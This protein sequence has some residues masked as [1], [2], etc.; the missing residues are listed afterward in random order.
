MLMARLCALILV[1]LLA[2]S[3]AFAQGQKRP[4]APAPPTAPHPAP[5]P[6]RMAAPP[7]QR[8]AAPPSAHFAAPPHPAP[9]MAAPPHPAPH[10]AGPAPRTVPPGVTSQRGASPGDRF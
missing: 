6:P 5:Q 1:S 7:P 4:G 10:T 8:M 2:T 9:H 3:A